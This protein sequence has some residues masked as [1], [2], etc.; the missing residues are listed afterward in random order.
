M[1]HREQNGGQGGALVKEDRKMK[2]DFHSHSVY[3]KH[4]IWGNEAFGRPDQM[5]DMAISKGLNGLAITDHN[6]VRGSLEGLRHA[7]KIKNFLLIPGTEVSSREGHIVALGVKEDIS[8]KLTV[9]ETIDRVHDL[10]GLAIAAHPYAGW[11]RT[12]SLGDAIRKYK[13][14]AIE[15]LNGGTR[16]NANRKAYRVA[17]EMG[18]PMTAGSDSHYWKDLGL[19]YNLVDCG[20]SVD[21]VLRAIRKGKVLPQGRPFGFYT[22]LRLATRKFVRSITSRL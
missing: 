18:V 22:G 6:S 3:S 5:I 4:T 17:K 21:S 12:A 1:L 11:P 13:F 8:R 15:V 16:V 7:K 9:P 2:I 14:D 19:I 10:G 20:P